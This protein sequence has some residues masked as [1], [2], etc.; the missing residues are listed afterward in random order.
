MK[1]ALLMTVGTGVGAKEEQVHSLAHGLMKAILHYKPDMTIFFGS[2]LS[3]NTIDSI[4]KQYKERTDEDMAYRFIKIQDVDSFDECYRK[5]KD[6]IRVRPNWDVIID[7]TSGTKTMTMSAAIASVL[8]HKELTLVSGERGRNGLVSPHTEEIRTQSLYSA[9]DDLLMDKLKE[10]F[11]HYRFGTALE[12]LKEIVVLEN[13]DPYLKLVEAYD[14]WDKFNHQEAL[15]LISESDISVSDEVKF[16]R[17]KK[18]LGTLNNSK[19]LKEYYLLADLINNANRRLM[20]GKYDDALARLYRAVEFISQVRLKIEYEIDTSDVNLELIPDFCKEKY[21]KKSGNRKIKLGL[22]E[23]YKLLL[24]L[25]DQLGSALYDDE[26][27][28]DVLSKRNYSILAHGFEPITGDKVNLVFEL[29]DKVIDLARLLYPEIDELM[30][31][32]E[33]MKI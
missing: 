11:N 19:K 26:R 17:N 16:S 32:A 25:D 24:E 2:D 33:F 31:N 12:F 3:R 7:Y 23:G 20:E 13:K 21:R 14:Y 29:K 1:R 22:R 5:I 4:R 15:R 27:L 8:Y 10:A 6:E 28:L 9:Y 30:S 18:F